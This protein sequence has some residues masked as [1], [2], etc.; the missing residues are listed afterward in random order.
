MSPEVL[1]DMIVEVVD[2]EKSPGSYK[3]L[4]P[5]EPYPDQ[6]KYAGYL[7]L[8]QKTLSHSK[9]Q[10]YWTTPAFQN[11]D[12]YNYARDYVSDSPDHPIFLRTYKTR[13]DQYT[14]LAAE[15]VLTGLWQIKLTNAGSGYDPDSP[16]TV[17]IGGP[18]SAA[19]AVAL[20]NPDGT[21]AWIRITS[22]GSGYTTAPIIT[23][24]AP[25]SGVTATATATVQGAACFLISQKTQNFPED[26]PRFSLFL[27]ETR[28]YQAFPGPVLSKWDL[29][30]RL[31]T[32]VK[33]DKQLVL[34]SA[35]PANPNA[36]VLADNVTVEYQ[37]LTA[38]YS[39]KITTT[40]T[41]GIAW[42]NGGE[43]FVY[44]GFVSHRFPDQITEDPVVIAAYALSS[45]QI[46]AAYGWDLKVEEGYSG[47]CQ[48]EI[49]ERYTFDPTNTAFI[50]A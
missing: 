22:E 9:V 36:A 27:I 2:T 35:V 8:A 12:L 18:G 49:R 30:P 45:N 1:D 21:I 20:V 40:I 14:T 33:V 32:L 4:S 15:A 6:S 28:V 17:T 42:E 5:G 11:Q 34:K 3:R 43:D 38:R 31:D 24:A 47:P 25:T 37:D 41:A 46:A 26:D 50:A 19:T 39:A 23:I 16:P 29:E 7:F 13:R 44:Q 10:Q 48:A